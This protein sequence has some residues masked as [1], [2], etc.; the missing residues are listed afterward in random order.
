MAK[1]LIEEWAVN[2]CKTKSLTYRD[3]QFTFSDGQPTE[4]MSEALQVATKAAGARL[5]V[6][7][8]PRTLRDI[9]VPCFGLGLADRLAQASADRKRE[10]SPGYTIPDG[11]R[12][13]KLRQDPM[14]PK[15]PKG[16]PPQALEAHLIFLAK[17]M[18][19]LMHEDPNLTEQ[20]AHS[21]ALEQWK[22]LPPAQKALF[23]KQEQEEQ[24][25]YKTKLAEYQQSHKF[26]QYVVKLE[27]HKHKKEIFFSDVGEVRTKPSAPSPICTPA[28]EVS[29]RDELHNNEASA[30]EKDQKSEGIVSAA[31]KK[32]TDMDPDLLLAL[33][34]Y[35]RSSPPD[36]PVYFQV[37]RGLRGTC[38][39]REKVF[40]KWQTFIKRLDDGIDKFEGVNDQK[41]F[42]RGRDNFE[43]KGY[44]KDQKVYWTAYTSVSKSFTQA[45][46]F[47][48]NPP[49]SPNGDLVLFKLH[50]PPG[51][52]AFVKSVSY[53]GAEEELLLPR[54]SCFNVRKQPSLIKLHNEQSYWMCE[55][56]LDGMADSD[57]ED[58]EDIED[59]DGE[60]I[61][62]GEG[63]DDDEDDEK[64][65]ESLN[66]TEAEKVEMEKYLGK[67]KAEP[68][69]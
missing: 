5:G 13:A 68:G 20:E 62:D 7:F 67:E 26:Q 69:F 45:R 28:T 4:A 38:K 25:Q 52:G 10:L 15:P 18:R 53:F 36:P 40:D 6:R 55:M 64:D 11:K 65:D 35:T 66:W 1:V 21:R 16:A 9:F 29:L 63:D 59:E 41:V 58:G 54:D 39:D 61:E 43:H 46:H 24:V 17:K 50:I 48:L 19:E 34:V 51:F 3:G 30:F 44:P 37:N 32:Y 33:H 42:Y 57:I 22:S 60:D 56:S 27:T 47:T 49:H 14:E 23:E 12:P 8:P 31:C 2:W